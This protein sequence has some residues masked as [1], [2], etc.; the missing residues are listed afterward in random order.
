[1]IFVNLSLNCMG[2]FRALLSVW[3]FYRLIASRILRSLRCE[4]AEGLELP[5]MCNTGYCYL[6]FFFFNSCVIH[7]RQKLLTVGVGLECF[8][9]NWA[10]VVLSILGLCSRSVGV[11]ARQF[12][13]CI[14]H[15]SSSHHTHITSDE[16]RFLR[17]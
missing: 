7:C 3:H 16:N 15:K 2:S 12:D 9:F 13:V 5:T 11:Y 17:K 1:M 14:M 4:T 6:R 8:F 10:H